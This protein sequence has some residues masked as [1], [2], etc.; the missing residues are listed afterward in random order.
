M[1]GQMSLFDFIEP[2]IKEFSWDADINGIHA[3][4]VDMASRMHIDV[5]KEAWEV[6]NHVPQYGYRMS[7]T[8]DVT[9]EHL[10][11]E[12]FNEMDKIIAEALK[13]NIEISFTMPYFIGER[14][15]PL[16]SMYVYSTFLDK[17]RKKRK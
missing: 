12:F 8:L 13:R 15:R 2:T 6:W 7:L 14:N 4:I 17:E 16:T 10:T 1:Q 11:D 9:K 5:T 3:E